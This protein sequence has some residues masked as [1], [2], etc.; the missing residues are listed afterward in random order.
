MTPLP[1]NFR[2]GPFDVI[3]ARGKQAKNH[4]G[5]VYFRSLVK[6]SVPAYSRAC[7]RMQKSMV[8][9]NIIDTI[10]EKSPNGGFVKQEA[11]V[12]Y[13]VG[14]HLAREKVGQTLRDSLYD[15]YKS[16]TKAKR[17]R[18]QE[19]DLKMRRDLEAVVQA[20]QEA[21]GRMQHLSRTLQQQ[22]SNTSDV[23]LLSLMNETNR[24][25]LESFKND[26]TLQQFAQEQWTMD[27]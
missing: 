18:K 25:L 12:W 26:K 2:P 4:C 7:S 20:N 27:G 1:S 15:Q 13:N 10:H 5:N 16:S 23:Y 11:G 3:C 22:D 21:C 17:Q 19:V 24:R 14:D 8:V 6:K 9:S